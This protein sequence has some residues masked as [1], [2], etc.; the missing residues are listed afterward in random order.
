MRL[1]AISGC[2]VLL[3]LGVVFF[4][5]TTKTQNKV[6]DK[7]TD[8][9]I[10]PIKI[11]QLPSQQ[12]IIPIQLECNNARLPI[13]NTLED[14]SCILTNNTD[15]SITAVVVGYKI[16][17]E[18][19]AGEKE[20]KPFSITGAIT[21]ETLIHTSLREQRK[22]NFIQPKETTTV[23]LLPTAF[24]EGY[25]ISEMTM[26]VDFVEFE[27]DSTI[28]A[29]NN[30]A[31]TV[32]EIRDGATRYKNWLVKNLKESNSD[33]AILEVLQK[34]HPKQIAE[35]EK[36]SANQ[37]EGANVFRKFAERTFSTKGH[38]GLSQILK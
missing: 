2:L 26:W 37:I 27:D 20:K 10:L 33:S 13:P 6:T 3:V 4:S 9:T 22:E 35:L 8:E 14:V 23:T 7:Q 11:T 30:G 34:K 25:L 16:F 36:L 31:R 19:A 38:K 21:T 18:T 1:A 15:K 17:S 5:N 28:G 29:A 24:D 32:A 12:N